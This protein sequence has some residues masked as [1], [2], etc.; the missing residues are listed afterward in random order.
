MNTDLDVKPFINETIK[1]LMGYSER[2]GILSPQAVQCFNNALNQSL[3]NRYDTSFVFETLLTIIESA[4]K[5]DLKFNF[6]RVLRNTKGR[7]FSG[8]VLDFD[9][10]FNNIKFT[11]KDNSL[12]F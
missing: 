7:D 3:I 6:D 12:S 10:V 11:A 8:N 4:S 5:R 2:S 1:A 9:S